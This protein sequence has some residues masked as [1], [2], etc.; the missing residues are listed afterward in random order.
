MGKPK[1]MRHLSG[2]NMDKA[3]LLGAAKNYVPKKEK[4]ELVYLYSKPF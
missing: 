3:Q 4:G 2:R 1:Q